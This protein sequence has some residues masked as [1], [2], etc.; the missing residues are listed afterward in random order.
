M[1]LNGSCA[2][3]LTSRS[4]LALSR[5]R[6]YHDWL[7]TQAS[8]A[9]LL[10]PSERVLLGSLPGEP[11]VTS[12]RTCE[13]VVSRDSWLAQKLT[14]AGPDQLLPLSSGMAAGEVPNTRARYLPEAG[15]ISY[16]AS[17]IA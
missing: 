16:C 9:S 1:A 11:D 15:G 17:V 3:G 10:L 12:E 13:R 8:P 6:H 2:A 4:R 7:G 14:E 5:R